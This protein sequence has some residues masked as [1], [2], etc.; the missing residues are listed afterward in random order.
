MNE[1]QINEIILLGESETVE[2][3]RSTSELKEAI[4]SIVLSLLV[5]II[6]RKIFPKMTLI[7]VSEDLAKSEGVNI[8][9][10]N[11]LYLGCIA[12]I[13]ALGVKLVGGL[14]TA[15]LVAIPAVTARNL[16]KNMRTYAFLAPFFGIVSAIFGILLFKLVGGLPAGP[17]IILVS[18]FLFLISL[19]F[20]KC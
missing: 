4:I 18:A 15:A 3:K 5:F 7:G 12:I 11:F 20:K 2:F 19:V 17:L 14:L 6:V 9:K 16:S 8:K 10:Y 13:V 1:K